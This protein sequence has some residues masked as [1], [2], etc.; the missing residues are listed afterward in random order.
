M[1]KS[2]LPLLF[3]LPIALAA[4]FFGGCSKAEDPASPNGNSL[5]KIPTDEIVR[6]EFT[7]DALRD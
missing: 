1:K 4:L 2:P 7:L 5:E 3:I 6:F